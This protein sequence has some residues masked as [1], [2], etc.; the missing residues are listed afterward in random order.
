M[1]GST[2]FLTTNQTDLSRIVVI[3]SLDS[4]VWTEDSKFPGC[5]QVAA[6]LAWLDYCDQVS[7]FSLLYSP[8]VNLYETD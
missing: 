2:V 7:G 3:F 8:L 1:Q 5:R 4:P 6:F